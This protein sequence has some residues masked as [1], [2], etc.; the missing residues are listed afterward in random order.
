MIVVLDTNVIVS[1]LLSPKGIPAK[2][3]SYLEEGRITVATSSHLLDELEHVLKYTKI[4]KY[5][6]WSEK[7]IDGFIK[8]FS[9][10]TEVVQPESRLKVIEKDLEDDRVLEC[11]V[12]AQASFI[13]T[14]D[15]H[16]LGLQEFK[17]IEIIS[18]TVFVTWFSTMG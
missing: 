10:F 16:L 17:G 11:A 8:H 18:P 5:V 6:H 15:Q 14:G 4:V 3:L 12:A 9:A 13:I 7:D 2:I 1:A